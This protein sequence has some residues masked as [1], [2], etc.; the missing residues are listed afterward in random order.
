M[1]SIYKNE[2]G[3]RSQTEWANA[4]LWFEMAI[5]ALGGGLFLA[6]ALYGSLLAMVIGVVAVI[7]LKGGLLLADLGQP[8]RFMNVLK[9]P[10]ESWMSFGALSFLLFSICGI[11]VCA[12]AYT[13]MTGALI[14]V[15]VAITCVFAVC[16]V[17]YEGFMLMSSVGIGAWNGNGVLAP[18]F[19]AS[20]FAGGLGLL[21]V[22]ETAVGNALDCAQIMVL[23]LALE[24]VCAFSY[25]ASL[26]K[27][28]VDARESYKTLMDGELKGYYVYGVL[29]LGIIVPIVLAALVMCVEMPGAVLAA[30]GCCAAFGVVFMR[31]AV[32]KCGIYIPAK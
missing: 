3:F 4:A 9:R 5:G 23:A 7:V 22:I 24:A 26:Q 31:I 16:L 15:A 10:F 12:M 14:Q 17:S 21:C 27:G 30:A 8:G 32:L 20:A 25:A 2:I 28:R 13:G 6:G 1:R 18:M 19:A 29:A 11:I